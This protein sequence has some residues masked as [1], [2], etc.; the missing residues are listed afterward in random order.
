MLLAPF[1]IKSNS[2]AEESPVTRWTQG[3]YEITPVDY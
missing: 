1:K 2:V 3:E